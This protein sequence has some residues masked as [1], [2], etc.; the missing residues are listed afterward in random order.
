V[1]TDAAVSGTI[2]CRRGYTAA[3]MLLEQSDA[4][5]ITWFIGDDLSRLGRNTIEFSGSSM[6][7]TGSMSRTRRPR[8]CCRSRRRI[9]PHSSKTCGRRCAAAWTTPSHGA[10]TSSRPGSVTRR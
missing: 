7:A 6:P 10:R 4:L 3:K 9:T 8:S 5:G 2:A 1:W